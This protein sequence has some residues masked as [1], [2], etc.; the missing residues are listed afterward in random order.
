MKD[1][2]SMDIFDLASYEEESISK[3]E[4]SNYR[5]LKDKISD[6]FD[7]FIDLSIN[8]FDDETAMMLDKIT[9]CKSFKDKNLANYIYT[10]CSIKKSIA[11][12]FDFEKDRLFSCL[13]GTDDNFNTKCIEGKDIHPYIHKIIIFK[14]YIAFY[15]IWLEDKE[16]LDNHVK[17]DITHAISRNRGYVEYDDKTYVIYKM[18]LDNSFIDNYKSLDYS[19]E[20]EALSILV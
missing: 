12:T 9:G 17:E 6:L 7:H 15:Y 5:T 14:D 3:I 8:E 16:K 2:E 4:N 11:N 13:Y 1:L 10:I 19:K 20:L 18:E